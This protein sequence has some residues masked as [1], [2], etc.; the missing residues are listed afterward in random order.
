MIPGV[1]AA[2]AAPVIAGIPVTHRGAANQVLISTGQG[3]GGSLPTLS[4]Y[5]EGRTL[6]LLMAV[7][8]IPRLA[9]DLA[10]YPQES[11]VAIIERASH[12][13]ERVTHTTL[14]R[15]AADAAAAGVESPA[16]IV[17][18]PV[19]DALRSEVKDI[20]AVIEK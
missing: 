13:D 19:V 14:T 15:L 7:G 10:D 4:P 5:V 9:S 11:P 17:I 12:P 6:V 20:E 3:R 2:L 1:C 16:V 8:R 18:G